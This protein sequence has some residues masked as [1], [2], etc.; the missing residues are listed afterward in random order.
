M[1]ARAVSARYWLTPLAV[2]VPI[3]ATPPLALWAR[4]ADP[5]TTGPVFA[6]LVLATGL[7]AIAATNGLRDL[8]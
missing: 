1:V 3:G 2:L 6:L 8:A 7:A 4:S 5:T